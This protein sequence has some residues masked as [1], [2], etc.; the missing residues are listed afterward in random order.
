MAGLIPEDVITE[1]RER[2][3]IVQV[4][5][6]YVE[7]KRSGANFMGLCPFHDEKTPSF[8]VNK[9][10]QFYHCFGCHE[11]GDVFSFLM[12]LEGRNFTEV[13]EDLA[14]RASVEIKFQDVSPARAQEAARRK[15][16]RQ[17]GLDLNARVSKMYRELLLADGGR[18]ARS[19]LQQRGISDEVAETFRIGFAPA[20]GNVVTRLVQ[21]LKVPAAFAEKMGLIARR[22]SG[23]G[24]HDRFWNRVIF[25]VARGGGEILGF[26]GRRLGD[27][28]GPKYINTP[29]T[30]LYTKGEALF[31]MEAA[32]LAIRRNQTVLLVEGNL[33]VIQ[34]F[35]HGFEHTLAPMGTALTPRQVT[36]LR[37]MADQVVAIFDGDDAGQAAALKAV[38]MF[39][40]YEVPAKI[41]A[42]PP[43]LDPDDFLLQRGPEA[44]QQLISRAAPAVDF[45][46]DRHL[47]QMEDTVPGRAKVLEKA[48]PVVARIKDQVA[49]ELYANK[50]AS[51]LK[52]DMNT[53]RRAVAAGRAPT[54]RELQP[55]HPPTQRQLSDVEHIEVKILAILVEHPHLVHRAEQSGVATLL[56]NE[57][58]RATYNTAVRMQQETGRIDHAKLLQA[59]PAEVID[60]VAKEIHSDAFAA[61]GDP[62]KA[63]DDSVARLQRGRLKQ[64]RTEIRGLMQE[65]KKNE[66]QETRRTLALRLVELEREIHETR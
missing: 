30:L 26:G 59:T 2:T 45:L 6:Q 37:R 14:A 33:D 13:V 65:A 56:T 19:Y 48:V 60:I 3:D 18:Q 54:P 58:L 34:M 17:L 57:D 49:R 39:V 36:L 21:Q 11:S 42:L 5:G 20:S 12:K 9:P 51:F 16:D 23:D 4:V 64:E 43:E 50:L 44:M 38:P 35:Q 55:Q 7:L 22:R 27:G 62:T 15:S 29:E 28:D 32:T 1:V 25:P 24:Y 66:D 63:L 10:K 52:V 41:A 61:D 47:Q 31:G 53:V 40:Q 46:I 8:S